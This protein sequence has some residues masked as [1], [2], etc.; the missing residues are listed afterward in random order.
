[1]V[2]LEDRI[3]HQ[4][5]LTSQSGVAQLNSFALDDHQADNLGSSRSQDHD[6]KISGA[7]WNQLTRV[8]I[9]VF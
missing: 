3:R 4:E 6:Q 1:M 5:V 9:P 8:F 2:V 7:L